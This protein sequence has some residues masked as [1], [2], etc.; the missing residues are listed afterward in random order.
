MGLAYLYLPLP[1]K[2]QP[3]VA[4]LT[5]YHTWMMWKPYG[6]SCDFQTQ[7]HCLLFDVHLLQ[8]VQQLFS[9]KLHGRASRFVLGENGIQNGLACSMGGYSLTC[10]FFIPYIFQ[11]TR[12]FTA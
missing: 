11:T 6:R 2:Q 4:K 3:Y 5:M 1:K 10:K 8:N 7:N 12:A 9:E